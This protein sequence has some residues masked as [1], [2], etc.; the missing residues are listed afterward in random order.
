MKLLVLPYI[1]FS[2]LELAKTHLQNQEKPQSAVQHQ[3]SMMA[4]NELALMLDASLQNMMSMMASQKQGNQNCE[5]PGGGKPK[6]GQ[7]SEKLSQMGQKVDKLQ[8]GS[9]D[10]K[11]KPGPSSQEIGEI[12]SEQEALRRMIENA[13]SEEKGGGGN[14]DQKS[15]LLEDLDK[16]EDLLLDKNIDAYKERMKR[17]ETRLLE[18]EKALEERKQKEEREA[19]SGGSQS[20]LDGSANDSI[21]KEGSKDAYQRSVLN[22]VPFYQSLIYGKN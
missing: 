15:E 12:L 8:K 2:S 11:G 21:N 3:Y 9:K 18:N 4:A 17:V 19:E 5:K 7:M 22:L 16:M 10:G 14:G 6:P 20:M 13:E 1:L